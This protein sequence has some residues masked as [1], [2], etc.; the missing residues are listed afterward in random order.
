MNDISIGM[1]WPPSVNSYW[2]SIV[3][4]KKI[5]ALISRAGRKYR[6][7][8]AASLIE[9]GVGGLRIESRLHVVIVL[10]GPTDAK[11]DVDNF[12]KGIFDALTYAQVWIDD[13]QVDHL[14]VIRG[15]KIKGGHVSV[16]LTSCTQSAINM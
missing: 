12:T 15:T 10:H 1:P 9:Q 13:S 7:D 8:A 6:D 11:R 16:V 14:E 5:R 2:R 4:G 3:V